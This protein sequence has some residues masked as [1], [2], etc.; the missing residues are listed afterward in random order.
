MSNSP[1]TNSSSS[2][3]AETSAE[4]SSV[5]LVVAS[6]SARTLS[7]TS[8]LSLDVDPGKLSP[9]SKAVY[10]LIWTPML[11]GIKPGEIAEKLQRAPSW[12]SD[13]LKEF[14]TEACFQLGVSPPL[15]KEEYDSLRASIEQFGVQVP[16][17]VDEHG[18][19]IEGR[20]RRV[21]ARDLGIDCPTEVRAGLTRAQ[22]RELAN[23]LN[24]SR[25]QMNRAQKRA[26][27]V[28]EL[29]ADRDRSDRQVARI[30]GVDGKTVGK[31]RALLEDEEAVYRKAQ[32]VVETAETPRPRNDTAVTERFLG[33][34]DCPHC[35]EQVELWRRAGA[36]MLDQ[37]V[38]VP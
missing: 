33:H 35:Q 24:A 19:V 23:T 11:S 15:T 21:I 27:I 29:M 7:W 14:Y 4:G 1:A 25:R 12:V 3:S 8:E 26:L 16:V 13:R 18:E 38:A 17:I 31:V 6:Q 32:G 22:Q 5:E 30:A 10:D 2:T 9:R 36:Y 34:L 20:W 37:P 28:A